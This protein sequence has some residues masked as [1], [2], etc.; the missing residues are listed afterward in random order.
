M[1]FETDFKLKLKT[2]AD[3]NTDLLKILIIW[4]KIISIGIKTKSVSVTLFD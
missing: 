2:S 3:R 1:I 4:S